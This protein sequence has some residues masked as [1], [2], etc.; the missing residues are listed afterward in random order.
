MVEDTTEI[1][2]IDQQLAEPTPEAPVE[3][4]SPP[5]YYH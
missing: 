3:V 5:Q 4:S 1:A 2:P